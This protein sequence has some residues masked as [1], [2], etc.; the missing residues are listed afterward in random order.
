MI[1][2]PAKCLN[3]AIQSFELLQK[4]QPFRTYGIKYIKYSN[5]GI[6]RFYYSKPK[7]KQGEILY[8]ME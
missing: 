5:T 2:I 3:E 6:F 4:C 8:K 7:L 1:K